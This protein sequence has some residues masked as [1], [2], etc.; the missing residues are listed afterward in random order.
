MFVAL[1][2]I[3]T[4]SCS[5]LFAFSNPT[6]RL[7]FAAPDSN[8][9]VGDEA[10][11]TCHSEEFKGYEQT[12][13]HRTSQLPTRAT[14]LGKFTAGSDTMDTLDPQVNFRMNAKSDAFFETAII[15]KPAHKQTRTE[16]I[17][18]VVGSGRKGQT[19]LYWKGDQLFELPVSYWTA[20]D[21]WVNSPGYLDGSADF[22]RPI[23]PRCLECHA[24]SFASLPAPGYHFDKSNFTLG[25][26]C[27]RCHGP[28]AEHVR[29]HA[30]SAS[31]ST[32]NPNP[33][34]SF[35]PPLPPV[36]IDRARQIDICAQCHGGMGE[37][38]N[39]PFS[40]RPGE[41]LANSIKL[42]PFNPRARV[43]VHGNQVALL[44]KSRCFQSSATMHCSTCH[45]LHA[46]EREAAGYSDR[47]LTCHKPETCPTFAK[48]PH[49]EITNCIDCHMPIQLS[50]SLVLDVDEQQVGAQV[51]THWIRVYPKS[52][53]PN[54]SKPR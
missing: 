18:L 31:A 54:L 51:R 8:G 7:R 23:T 13:H 5:V 44:E 29:R 9:Y 1:A 6:S 3:L 20:T 15:S 45:D 16:R 14:V 40:Y 49:Q 34:Q 4:A 53:Q 21:R 39:P 37:S 30:A 19:Y 36:G 35:E 42:E 52:T 24:T 2:L 26:S 33:S 32:A 41:P 43:D 50:K 27:E 11:R 12:R 17:D 46:P 48:M 10:C 22:D 38:V 25:I 28:S 47:C